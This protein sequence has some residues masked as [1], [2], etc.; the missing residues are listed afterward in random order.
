MQAFLAEIGSLMGMQKWIPRADHTAVLAEWRNHQAPLLER[1][2][3]NDDD[4]TLRTIVRSVVLWQRGESI[5]RAF[6]V[7]HTTSIY[8]GILRMADLLALQPN[9]AIRLH[10]VEPAHRREKINEEIQRP[11]FSLLERG[12]LSESCTFIPI[13]AFGGSPS[14]RL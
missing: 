1:L 7:E 3:L 2:P 4:T 13:T 12:A 9:M 10:I 14:C 8:S 6:E 5:R 11:V